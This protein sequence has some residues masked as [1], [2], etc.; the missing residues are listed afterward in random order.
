MNVRDPFNL[1]Q[2]NALTILKGT[3]SRPPTSRRGSWRLAHKPSNQGDKPLRICHH[4][5][6]QEMC[7]L[8]RTRSENLRIEYGAPQGSRLALRP[9]ITMEGLVRCRIA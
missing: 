3:A 9:C 1:R 4:F 2:S 7:L 6:S 8:L 5:Q